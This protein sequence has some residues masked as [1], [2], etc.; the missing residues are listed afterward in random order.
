[1]DGFAGSLKTLGIVGGVLAFFLILGF[2][3]GRHSLFLWAVLF[4][5]L[6]PL[7]FWFRLGFKK[8]CVASLL[9]AFA[10]AISPID[11][12]ITRLERPGARLVLI[13]YGIACQ[14]GTVCYGCLVTANS[15]RKALVLSY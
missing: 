2:L 1:M 3:S 10:L 5:L 4:S 7:A 6:L 14:P 13:S 9:I 12:V 15:P 8:W 11:I